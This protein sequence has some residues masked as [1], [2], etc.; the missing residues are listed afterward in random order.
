MNSHCHPMY[1]SIGKWFWSYLAGISPTAAGF[2]EVKI[3]PYMPSKLLMTEATL[4]TCKGDISVRW[5]KS[6]GAARLLVTIPSGVTAKV[7]IPTGIETIDGSGTY[8]YEF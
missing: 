5:H 1:G 8:F 6:Y 7:H 4:D 2:S 3:A